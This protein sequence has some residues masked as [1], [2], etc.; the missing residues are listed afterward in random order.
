MFPRGLLDFEGK[1]LEALNSLNS[2][3]P[4]NELETAVLQHLH[5]IGVFPSILEDEKS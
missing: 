5:R 4:T 3:A 1:C 2:V